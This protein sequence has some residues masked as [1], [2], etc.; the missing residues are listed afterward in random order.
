MASRRAFA[1]GLL[2][3]PSPSSSSSSFS[4]FSSS[5]SSSSSSAPVA[6]AQLSLAP[7]RHLGRV[8]LQ[9]SLPLGRLVAVRH[10]PAA[11]AACGVTTRALGPA[12]ARGY[13]TGSEGKPSKIWDFEGVCVCFL[14]VLL[15]PSAC[16]R[17]SLVSWLT[18]LFF[19]S[20]NSFKNLC[21]TRT[22]P[23]P[24]L[25]WLTVSPQ[26]LTFFFFSLTYYPVL[27]SP[28]HRFLPL[29]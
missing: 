19:F 10:S 13:S 20:R 15:C 12:L 14:Y 5:S 6:A 29:P 7:R 11:C 21:R 24:S 28:T 25:V 4:S 3:A 23:S 27:L 26:S 8:A 1:A 16:W 22:P 17:G 18:D 2:R 9:R